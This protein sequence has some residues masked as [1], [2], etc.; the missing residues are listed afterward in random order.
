MM[1]ASHTASWDAK[2][3][4]GLPDEMELDFKYIAH[5]FGDA[6]SPAQDDT[7]LSRLQAL[8]EKSGV[9]EAELQKVVS[10]KDKY[11]I[12]TPVSDYESKFITGWVIK[13]W[14]QIMPINEPAGTIN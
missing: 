13:Y 8:M 12:D 9:T 4:H 2:N 3:R 6:A 10:D 7:P 11:P 14:D 1:Y 5:L